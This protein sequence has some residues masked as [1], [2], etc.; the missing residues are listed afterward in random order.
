M[1]V[2]QNKFWVFLEY[3]LG[4]FEGIDIVENMVIIESV[5][6]VEDVVGVVSVTIVKG[7]CRGGR[8]NPVEK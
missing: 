2:G 5:V 6:S 7:K 8:S 3:L 4:V 1:G